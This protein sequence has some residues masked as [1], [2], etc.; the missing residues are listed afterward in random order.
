VSKTSPSLQALPTVTIT[1][2]QAVDPS[3]GFCSSKSLQVITGDEM[4]VLL[5]LL[6][7]LLVCCN[8]WF[9]AGELAQQV[10]FWVAATV[11]QAQIQPFC[12]WQT[13]LWQLGK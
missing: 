5:L 12:A 4:F 13:N 2:G 9:M 1:A 11:V 8:W 7:L 3:T 10:G 6:D